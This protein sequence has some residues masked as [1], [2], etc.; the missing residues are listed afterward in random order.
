MRKTGMVV[1]ALAWL[2]AGCGGVSTRVD[3]D[4]TYSFEE[5]GTYD[6]VEQDAPP[7]FESATIDVVKSTTDDELRVKGYLKDPENPTFL[8]GYQLGVEAQHSPRHYSNPYT[9]TGYTEAS[10]QTRLILDV[11][12]PEEREAVWSGSASISVDPGDTHK[13]APPIRKAVRKLLDEVPPEG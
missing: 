2:A 12:D 3:W 10:T 7:G 13:N 11:V 5:L 1:A 8:V 9:R 4:E 6:W